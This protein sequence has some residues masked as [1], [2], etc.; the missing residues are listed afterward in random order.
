MDHHAVR[1]VYIAVGTKLPGPK[2]IHV[3][4]EVL[5]QNKDPRP[6]DKL[7]AFVKVMG[8]KRGQKSQ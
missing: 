5:G 4:E 6:R 2:N 1:F 3:V 7:R 8:V